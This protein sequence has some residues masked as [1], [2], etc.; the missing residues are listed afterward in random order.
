[1]GAWAEESER[2]CVIT[3]DGGLLRGV[4]SDGMRSDSILGKRSRD[5]LR[6]LDI[7]VVSR[8]GEI[9][10]CFLN[11]ANSGRGA[12]AICDNGKRE[13]MRLSNSVLGI[14]IKD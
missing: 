12:L 2:E 7:S 13:G 9:H 3:C 11:V 8:L 14:M 10:V 4:P 1:M 6:W 5:Y